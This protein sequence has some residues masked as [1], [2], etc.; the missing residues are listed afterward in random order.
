MRSLSSGLTVTDSDVINCD[1][2]EEVGRL[3]Q[4]KLEN[5]NFLNGSMKRSDKV[6]TLMMEFFNIESLG[7]S[8]LP[9]NCENCKEICSDNSSDNDNITIKEKRELD[10]I[11]NGLVYD[12]IDKRWTVNYPRIKGELPLD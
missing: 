12:S 1:E 11:K 7:A 2:M 4:Q 10:M 9:S 6:M 5:E 8:L 3:L